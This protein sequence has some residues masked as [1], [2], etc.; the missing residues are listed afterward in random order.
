MPGPT[1]PK[2]NSERPAFPTPRELPHPRISGDLGLRGVELR[3]PH[4]LPTRGLTACRC[5][6]A[7]PARWRMGDP[8]RLPDRKIPILAH[9]RM[10]RVAR[11][12]GTG[13]LVGGQVL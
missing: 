1:L 5:P 3:A 6:S 9:D 4:P 10:A 12:S 8:N 13:V 2:Y 7:S 11:E